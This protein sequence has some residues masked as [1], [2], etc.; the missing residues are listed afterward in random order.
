[1]CLGSVRGDEGGELGQQMRRVCICAMDDM[2]CRDR[3]PCSFHVPSLI[4]VG[5]VFRVRGHAQGGTMCP[6]PAPFL[7]DLREKPV[8]KLGRVTGTRRPFIRSNSLLHPRP[9]PRLLS[10]KALHMAH[11]PSRR[12]VRLETLPLIL[13]KFRRQAHIERRRS[14]KVARNLMLLDKLIQL[15]K[16][17]LL[18][19][20]DF[21]G[22]DLAVDASVS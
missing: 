16:N 1:M 15:L 9:P 18:V 22:L 17:E 2:F 3:S 19:F 10:L 6:K 5:V 14:L 20:D 8:S 11:V 12:L 4:V 21:L 7:N 13:C